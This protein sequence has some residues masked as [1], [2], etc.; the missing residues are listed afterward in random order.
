[1]SAGDPLAVLQRIRQSRPGPSPSAPG[2]RCDLCG[3][4]IAEEHGHVVDRQ[5]RR[6]LCSCRGCHLLF[7]SE[8]A[9]GGHFA[10]VADE[11]RAWDGPAP[12]AADWEALQIPVSV[13][14]FFVNSSL[15]RI[16]AFYPGPAGVTESELPISAWT[17]LSERLRPDVEAVLVRVA[18]GGAGPD[19]AGAECYVVPIDA[20]YEL[21]GRLR[22]C[23]RGFDGG[24]EARDALEAFF[25]RVRA[26]AR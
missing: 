22:L 26:R 11:Y 24:P 12:S 2:E 15:D 8:G 17:D 1:V 6:L 4:P 25:A 16:A 9:G 23:W 21:A 5:T 7:S 14:F 19:S 20:C 18:P 10:A 13:A 3:E